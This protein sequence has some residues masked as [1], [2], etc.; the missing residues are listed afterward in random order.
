MLADTANRL[1][2]PEPCPN[3]DPS[4]FGF[5]MTCREGVLR[6]TIV[7]HLESHGVQTRMLFAGNLLRHPCFS[8]MSKAGVGYRVVGTLTNTNR[9]MSDT[10]WLGVYP[11]LKEEEIEYIAEMI[12]EKVVQQ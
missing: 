4:W 3:S 1:I 8:Q 9:I 11:G 7:E 6:S 12:K 5:M 10:F 2:L